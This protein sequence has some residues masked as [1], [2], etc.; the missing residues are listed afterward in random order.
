MEDLNFLQDSYQTQIR[1]ISHPLRVVLVE[2]DPVLGRVI[3]K[4]LEKS[5]ISEVLHYQCSQ[6]CLDSI[7]VEMDEKNFCLITDMSF[8]HGINGLLL[9]DALKDK[10]LSFFSIAMTGFGSIEN[11]ISAT[12]KGI[13]H[14][15]TKPFEMDSLC[16]LIIQGFETKFDYKVK[17][18]PE[19]T[20][21]SVKRPRSAI[22]PQFQ[23]RPF[24]EDDIF[25]GMIGRSSKMKYIFESIKKVAPVDSTVLITGP[26]GT[27]KELMAYAIHDLSL[28]SSERK[29]NV[30][31]GAIPQNLLESEL[32]GHARGAFTGAISDRKGRFEQAHK[33]TLFLDEIGDMPLALQ[34]KLLR[35]LQT[36]QIEPLG[37]NKSINVDVRIVAATHR[38]LE[39]LVAERKFREDLYYRLN[40]IPIK[41][42]PLKERSEDIWVLI[43]YFL[44]RYASADG[45]NSLDFDEKTLELLMSY[46]WPGNIRELGNIIERLVILRGG[47]TI[48]AKDL[49][50]KIYQHNLLASSLHQN[51]FNLPKGGVDI[52]NM[53]SQIE[54]SLIIQALTRTK[55]NKNQA[56]KLLRLNRTTLIEKMKKKGFHNST[57][58]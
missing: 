14:Y 53:L 57:T 29:V 7:E 42:P 47:H 25:C 22:G 6:Q 13:F 49:P 26:R 16:R 40:V 11:A 15:L 21:T 10:N 44:S 24:Q 34:V 41:V 55:G 51:I 50:S 20:Q 31:C 18:F 36:K 48:S 28:R 37:G 58:F 5:F 43:S 39:D 1:S 19:Q 12:K 27:G 32:F 38:N 8:E 45:S 2:D 30:N 56:S 54:D 4:Y 23:Q 46:D 17:H 9:I 33:G 52:K 3:K 35:V